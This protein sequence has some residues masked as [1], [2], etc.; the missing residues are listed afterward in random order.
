M[1]NRKSVQATLGL[2][3]VLA[4]FYEGAGSRIRTDDLLITNPLLIDRR[5]QI[6]AIAHP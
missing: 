6:S 4:R 2:N 1:Q 3:V 5:G